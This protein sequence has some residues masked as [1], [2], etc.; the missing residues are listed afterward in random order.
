MILKYIYKNII[1]A[2]L[3]LFYISIFV[4]NS[5][6]ADKTTWAFNN[7]EKYGICLDSFSNS[8]KKFIKYKKAA[9]VVIVD[10]D[11]NFTGLD[12]FKSI[13]E[14][15]LWKNSDDLPDNR[16]DDDSDGF[17]NN[18]Y[19]IELLK[20]T[21][22]PEMIFNISFIRKNKDT[23]HNEFMHGT[24]MVQIIDKI[25]A[26]SAVKVYL[27]NA[28][29]MAD[30]IEA[31]KWIIAEKKRGTNIKVINMPSTYFLKTYKF[32][33]KETFD[34]LKKFLVSLNFEE[35]DFILVTGSGNNPPDDSNPLALMNF[36]N[37]F[38][39]NAHNKKGEVIYKHAAK[40][41]HF[42]VPEIFLKGTSESST[43][44]SSIIA[45][46]FSIKPDY[47]AK[48]M[49]NFIKNSI[50]KDKNIGNYTLFKGYL[51]YDKA[52]FR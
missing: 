5:N 30:F 28:L 52:I 1:W 51:Q 18:Y 16:I 19:G 48:R 31:S 14:K 3:V 40:Y 44:A 17:I 7:K 47:S 4:I 21:S 33:D 26:S 23:F 32:T 36:D 13:I 2:V 22:D 45:T 11:I 25:A 50:V 37:I 41:S 34:A 42:S 12:K 24:T 10:I 20:R 49:V 43:V 35:Q 39:V 27:I 29:T 46:Y 38:S 8:Y 15:R 6:S 9:E